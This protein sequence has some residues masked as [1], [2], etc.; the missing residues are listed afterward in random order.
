[1]ACAARPM[2]VTVDTSLSSV[3][4]VGI[5]QVRLLR[6]SGFDMMK[7]RAH[8]DENRFFALHQGAERDTN[9]M[10]MAWKQVS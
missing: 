6:G 1:M 5:N 3:R 9:S 8:Q 7:I 4:C 10:L 2:A